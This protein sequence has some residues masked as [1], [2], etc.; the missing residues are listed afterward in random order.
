MGPSGSGKSTIGL[1]LAHAIGADFTDADDL[2]P[3]SNVAK[4]RAG[5]PL[6]DSDRWPW[7]TAVGADLGARDAAV[8]ACSA[9][10]KAYRDTIREQAPDAYFVELVVDE[11]VLQQRVSSRADHFMPASLVTSQLETLESLTADE[12][13]VRVSATLPVNE[14]VQRIH[15]AFTHHTSH[16]GSR[17]GTFPVSR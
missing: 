12:A 14:I 8:S 13:G 2:H 17:S 11:A 10:K 4:M 3:A 15:E 1:A 5:S 6:D 9:L 16:I 7:L